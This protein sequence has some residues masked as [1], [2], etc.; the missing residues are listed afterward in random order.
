MEKT[1][2]YQQLIQELNMTDI[3]QVKVVD[4][5]KI[6]DRLGFFVREGN[7]YALFEPMRKVYDVKESIYDDEDGPGDIKILSQSELIAILEPMV[8]NIQPIA[9]I[10]VDE[11]TACGWYFDTITRDEY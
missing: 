6:I 9:Y 4:G 10:D 5:K 8:N 7:E 1:R 3:F 2:T 11:N